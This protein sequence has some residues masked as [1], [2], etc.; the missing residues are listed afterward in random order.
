MANEKNEHE[1]KINDIFFFIYLFIALSLYITFFSALCVFRFC[2][3]LPFFLF[4]F[5]FEL[6]N[7]VT[8]TFSYDVD[9]VAR[10]VADALVCCDGST[11]N[12]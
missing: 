11:W 1:A 2:C 10:C 8:E 4:L 5:L 6:S 12:E 3:T 7:T 9:I